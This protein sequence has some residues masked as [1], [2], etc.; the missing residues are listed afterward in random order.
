MTTAQA[1]TPFGIPQSGAQPETF[2]YA[3]VADGAAHE[4]GGGILLLDHAAPTLRNLIIQNNAAQRG[5]GLYLANQSH[6]TLDTV[7]IQDNQTLGPDGEGAGVSCRTS[8]PQFTQVVIAANTTAQRGGGFYGNQC[9]A[10]L[11][12]VTFTRNTGARGGG[13]YLQASAPVVFA[14]VTLQGNQ[15]SD[16]GGALYATM[17]VTLQLANSV[18]VGNRAADAGGALYAGTRSSVTLVQSTVVQHQASSVGGALVAFDA[19]ALTV[20]NSIVWNNTPNTVRST[21]L[22]TIGFAHSI[23]GGSGGSAA[24]NSTFGTDNGGNWDVAPLFR[25]SPAPGADGVWGTLDDAY[26]NLQLQEGSPAI[27]GGDNSL[28]PTGL[29]TDRAGQP[30]IVDGDLN[31][32]A[33]VDMGA[34]GN[35]PVQ[36]PISRSRPAPLR[37][38]RPRPIRWR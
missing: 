37:R 18:L 7:T 36:H 3:D 16:D 20:Q 6:A 35:R 24:W 8:T 27:D 1:Y 4:T 25:Q 26:G 32:T 12:Q 5:A 34:Y 28:L 15:A 11:T 10:T 13:V 31:G 29:T 14:A 38:Q 33:T 30:R 17:D 22:S 19:T 21:N 23:V 9:P 2:G